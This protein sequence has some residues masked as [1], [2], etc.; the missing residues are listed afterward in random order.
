MKGI[1]SRA[2]GQSQFQNKVLRRIFEPRKKK[3][4]KVK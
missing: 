4:E 3:M 2:R 1:A